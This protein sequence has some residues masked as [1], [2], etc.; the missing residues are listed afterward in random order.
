MKSIIYIS[1][2]FYFVLSTFQSKAQ[3]TS[4]PS[5]KIKLHT[6]SNLLFSGNTLWFSLHYYNSL[7]LSD[8]ISSTVYI[9]LMNSEKQAIIR[10]KISLQN[11]MNSCFI[12]LPDT[13][14]TGAYT[15]LAYTRWMR[16]FGSNAYAKEK[17]AVINPIQKEKLIQKVDRKQSNHTDTKSKKLYHVNTSSKQNLTDFIP[18]DDLKEGNYSISIKR[19]EPKVISAKE[20]T[21]NSVLTCD[22]IQFHADYK[23]V[24]VDGIVT[25]ANNVPQAQSKV[26]LSFPGKGVDLKQTLTD[27]N[28]KFEFLIPELGNNIDLVFS[29]QD[30]AQKVVLLENFSPQDHQINTASLALNQSSFNYINEKY[31]YKQLY[32]RYNTK[33]KILSYAD[34]LKSNSTVFY[35]KPDYTYYFDQYV[36]LDSI[37]DYFYEIIPSVKFSK[38]K[39]GYR[40]KVILENNFKN[41]Q[42]EPGIFIDGVIYKDLNKLT[43]LSPRSVDRIEVLPHIY[44]Y[45][46]FIFNGIISIHTKKAD[47][48]EA[49]MQSN[50]FRVIFP[51]YSIQHQKLSEYTGKK[52][53][54]QPDLRYLLYWKPEISKEQVRNESFY[55][56]DIEGIYQ[57]ELKG[58]DKNGKWV[59]YSKD[60]FIEN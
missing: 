46:N 40:L 20:S 23:G 44:Y 9:E 56:S 12:N 17:I 51:L 18:I 41:L 8:T 29:L 14:S 48:L 24:V 37:Y 26:L 19:K 11:K 60:F 15:L 16:N 57:L 1:F 30:S 5:E 53:K 35:S 34:S 32:E 10:K 55:C 7:H 47:F 59:K 38:N 42:N 52:T 27:K 54:H 50:M 28:G 39:N 21:D 25:D 13:I 45:K 4:I 49:K 6:S 22:S 31:I 43:K 58:F 3:N 33:S 36:K 2:V